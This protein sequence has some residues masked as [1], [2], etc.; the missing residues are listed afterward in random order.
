WGWPGNLRPTG[1][2]DD[3][4]TRSNKARQF[5]IAELVQER[6]DIPI[7]R[8][9]PN[10][11]PRLK[12]AAD[13]CRLDSWVK[14]GAIERQ[15]TAFTISC[16]ANW[17]YGAAVLLREPVDRGKDLLHFVADNM[18]THFKRHPVNPFPVR[19]I[20]HANTRNHRPGILP[21]DQLRY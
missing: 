18:T 3:Q 5:R 17:K 11:L 7:D 9:L 20:R 21:I 14:S 4:S 15:Q 6:P 2:F 19:L 12:V 10:L 13:Q 16:D 1:S 8:L